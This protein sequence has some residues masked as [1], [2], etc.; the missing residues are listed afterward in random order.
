MSDG[1]DGSRAADAD[2]VA[3]AVPDGYAGTVTIDGQDI[4]VTLDQTL[5]DAAADNDVDPAR[6]K[7]AATP[8]PGPAETAPLDIQAQTDTDGATVPIQDTRKTDIGNQLGLEERDF[9]FIRDDQVQRL[10]RNSVNYSE[11]VGRFL[12]ARDDLIPSVKERM[13]ALIVGQEGITPEPAD[14]DTEADE[15]LADALEAHY[16]EEMRPLDRIDT[17][18]REN[19]M[20]ARA[21]LRATDLHELDV[22]ELTYLKDGV[23]GEEIY[24]QDQTTVY[25]F[26]VTD[27]ETSAPYAGIDLE[28][29]QVDAQPLV[30][31]DHVFD[32]ALYDAPPLE[33]IADQA[34]NKM[35][36]QRLKARKAEI[37]SYG[38][39]YAKVEPPQYLP[40]DD[41]FDRV[42]DDQ[43]D[44]DG[45]PPTKLERALQNNLD[46]AFDT[47]KDYQSGTVMS[48]PSNWEI[49]QLDIPESATPLD[50]QIRGYNQAIARR[51]LIPLDLIELQEGAEL[52]R[53]TMFRTLLTTIAGWRQEI[54]RVFDAFAQAY[55]DDHGMAGSVEHSFPPLRTQDTE[56]IVQ[57][58]QY[59]GIAG[60]DQSEVRDLLNNVDGIDLDTEMQP[61]TPEPGGDGSGPPMPP[62]GGPDDADER[63]EE[64]QQF[65]DEQRRGQDGDEDGAQ[66]GVTTLAE[67]LDADTRTPPDAVQNA[68]QDALDARD[69]DDVTVNG[70]TDTGW[71]RAE[72]LAAGEPLPPS[73]IVGSNDSMANWWARHMDH[74]IDTDGQASLKVDNEDNP[75]ADASYTA[76]KGWGGV[77]GAKW[78][79]R[80]AAR[81]TENDD[82]RDH[83]DSIEAAGTGPPAQTG[84]SG[85]AR[86]GPGPAGSSGQADAI[87]SRVPFLPDPSD[88]GT[89]RIPS[90]A[91]KS[92]LAWTLAGRPSI[93]AGWNPSLHPRGPDG[94]FIER[95]YDIPD[96]IADDVADMETTDV[97]D[98]L[99]EE[100][101]LSNADVEA[102]LTSD[103]I[104]ID[105]VPDDA[106]NR[107]DLQQMSDAAPDGGD[108]SD[109]PDTP[110]WA[111][112]MVYTSPDP[113]QDLRPETADQVDP[114]LSD[115]EGSAG[116]AASNM[117]VAKWGDGQVAFVKRHRESIDGPRSNGEKPTL[118]ERAMVADTF[119]RNIGLGDHVPD[120]AISD[121]DGGYMASRKVDGDHLRGS[122]PSGA[123][124]VDEDQWRRFQAAV[125]LAG[126]SDLHGDNVV[127]QDDGSFAA[128]DLNKSGGDFTTPGKFRS[129]GVSEL[130]SNGQKVL[131]GGYSRQQLQEDAEALA[132]ELDVDAA[133]DDIE[134][135]RLSDQDLHQF[136]DHLRRNIEAFAQGEVQL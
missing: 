134:N 98:S 28:R 16:D 123:D 52:S 128:I 63:T 27:D 136:R 3:A 87:L 101:E 23:T 17:I 81:I 118:A 111:D 7:A 38:A 102:L 68:A 1:M 67:E 105:R 74:T 11:R 2:D 21:V 60:L 57:A 82:W 129:R 108:G 62:E 55:A 95:P 107:Q 31:G 36:L 127:I 124:D 133:L 73:E 110:D 47:L 100:G 26:D 117:D 56:V 121:P 53:E 104:R 131:D 58:L 94:Q 106:T 61:D 96:D 120:I 130:V 89:T 88:D 97:L 119:M 99:V 45:T 78:A 40:E 15:Q 114:L 85:N 115:D 83:L 93:Q 34:V 70:M 77:A 48:I 41:Y 66:A 71:D 122:T 76:G 135:S 113:G 109:A 33:A 49:E 20:N 37:T 4:P 24:V 75:W 13:K 91:L 90:G 112:D 25:T 29:H 103:D 18:L 65:L 42:P 92:W 80:L 64:M 10:L 59:A 116:A 30:I 14:P 32:I 9:Q 54:T 84:G 35:V 86:R 19:L 6:L 132:Q 5:V 46:S 43:Y 12:L 126:N 51:M 39:V 125:L 69:S 22:R 50:D 8:G 72:M 44:G 79:F